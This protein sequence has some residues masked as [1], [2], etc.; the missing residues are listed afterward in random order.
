MP[1]S[2]VIHGGAVNTDTMRVYYTGTDT[3]KEGYALCWNF[4][5]FDVG[6]ENKSQ[7]SPVASTSDFND[8]RRLQVEKPTEGNKVHFAGVVS[9]KGN[10]VTGPGWVEIHRPGSICN[11]YAFADCDHG[12]SGITTGFGQFLTFM[13]NRW[14]FGDGGFPGCGS[15]TVLQDV[16]RTTTPGLVMVELQTGPQSCGYNLVSVLSTATASLLAA[17]LSEAPVYAGV[18]AFSAES[19]HYYPNISTGLNVAATASIAIGGTHLGKFVGQRLKLTVLSGGVLSTAF[20]SVAV[21]ALR[22]AG[23]SLMNAVQSG[24]LILDA[25]EDFIDI[26]WNGYEWSTVSASDADV[27]TT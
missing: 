21:T 14:Y 19:T 18:Y 22:R 4:D 16:D 8:A 26:E 17:S 2:T 7:T 27:F 15:A 6:A 9:Q 3:L 23:S 12:S 20:I 24:T 10:G 25:A 13:P 1:V 5:A 11:V